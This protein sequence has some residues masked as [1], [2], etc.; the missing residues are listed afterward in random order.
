VHLVSL[1]HH[2]E[3]ARRLNESRYLYEHGDW[4]TSL[5]LLQVAYAVYEDKSS[6]VYADLQFKAGSIYLD[7]N[8]L[9][10]CRG[11]WEEAHAIYTR[12]EAHGSVSAKLAMPWVLHAL[13]NL[14]SA[15]GKLDVALRLFSEAAQARMK[16]PLE[17]WREALA[18]MTAG[19]AYYLKREYT[20]AINR[21]DQAKKC[22]DPNSTWMA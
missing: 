8:D 3:Q 20:T 10:K 18:H 9:P 12:A 5:Q 7:Q 6:E 14:E 11:A 4:K 21:F 2:S 13:G 17:E 16:A 15:D 19:R 22:F 1:Y